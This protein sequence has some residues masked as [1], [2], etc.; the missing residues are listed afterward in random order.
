LNPSAQLRE[1]LPARVAVFDLDGTLV[2]AVVDIAS[3]INELLQARGLRPLVRE[4]AT[5]LLGDGLRVFAARA[6][7]LRD[8]TI[9]ESECDAFVAQYIAHPV[10]NTQLYPGVLSSLKALTQ[11]GWRLAVCTNKV[12]AAAKAILETLHVL[13]YFDVV[14]GAD[15]IEFSKPDPRHIEQTLA[16][17]GLLKCPAVMVG[18]NAADVAAARA[19]GIPS[20]FAA[21]G[22]GHRDMSEGADKIAERFSDLLVLLPSLVSAPE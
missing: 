19:Y 8:S 22:Y 11:A 15:T 5:S 20:I 6:F 12:E 13:E 9:S 4:E 1:G 7:S 21:W 3:G 2:D 14:C 18:D 17:A 16:R 10:V